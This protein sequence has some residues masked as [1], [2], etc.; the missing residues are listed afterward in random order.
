MQGMKLKHRKIQG[1][2]KKDRTFA[3]KTLFYIILSTV[4]FKVAPSTGGTPFPTFLPIVGMLP[5]TH[6]L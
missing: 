3:I 1:V 2:L 4:T 5:G 6:F